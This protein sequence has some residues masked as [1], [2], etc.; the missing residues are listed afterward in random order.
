MLPGKIVDRGIESLQSDGR[1]FT[2]TVTYSY[3]V[4]GK[5]YV[6]QQVYLTGR[7]GRTEDSAKRLIDGLPDAIPVHYNPQNPREVFLLADPAWIFWIATVFGLA[8]FV[9]G[10]L[11]VL[12]I[13][14]A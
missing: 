10:L 11:Q 1:S 14:M 5:E 12:A 6:G 4:A 9:W 2:P 7:V 8:A 13:T 3:S